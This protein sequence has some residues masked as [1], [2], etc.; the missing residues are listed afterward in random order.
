MQIREGYVQVHSSQLADL[1]LL[2]DRKHQPEMSSD[3]RA[4]FLAKFRKRLRNKNQDFMS[5]HGDVNGD[6]GRRLFAEMSQAEE[7]LRDRQGAAREVQALCHQ[8][9]KRVTFQWQG[10]KRAGVIVGR[11]YR[12]KY[13]IVVS[14]DAVI[15]FGGFIN[16]LLN[17]K[18]KTVI[19][20]S[21]IQRDNLGRFAFI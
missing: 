6:Y 9:G 8:V 21:C 3:E 13:S 17:D 7:A 15:Q 11:Y 2:A 14:M 19:P 4:K 18:G 5:D 16:P 20:I 1:L 12:N 10:Y